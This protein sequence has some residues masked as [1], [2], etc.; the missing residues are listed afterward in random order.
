M[1]R[2]DWNINDNNK[3]NFRFTRAHSKDNSGP[4]SSTSPLYAKQIYIKDR[5]FRKVRVM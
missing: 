5:Q 4:T 1:A 3:L 2:L